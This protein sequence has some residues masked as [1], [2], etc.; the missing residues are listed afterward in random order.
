MNK[1]TLTTTA[2]AVL[3]AGVALTGC[4][5]RES[6]ES[7]AANSNDSVIAQAE[8]KGRDMQADASR[9][10]DQAKQAGRDVA[11]DAKAATDKAGDKVADAVITTTVNA[12]LAKDS[13]LSALKI[14]VDTDNG[15][16]ALRGTAPSEAARERATQLASNVKGVVSVDNQL[17]VEPA[18]S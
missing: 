15:R 8:Q 11:Q 14:N 17:S 4:G 3:L 10:M 5:K 2:A 12:E 18:K 6:A 9:G 7:T 13:S 16:V 1:H